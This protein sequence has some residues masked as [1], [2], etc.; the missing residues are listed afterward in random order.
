METQ[1]TCGSLELVREKV[2][3]DSKALEGKKKP[4]LLSR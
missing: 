3:A 4:R 1:E 2:L